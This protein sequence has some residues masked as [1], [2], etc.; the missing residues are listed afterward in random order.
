MSY[1]ETALRFASST[2]W[3]GPLEGATHSGQ[4]GVKGDGPFAL[5][6][7][8]VEGGVVREARFQTYA[9]PAARA[10]CAALCWALQ[11]RETRVALSLEPSDVQ[12]LIHGLPEGKGHLFELAVSALRSALMRPGG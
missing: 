11:G 2:Q 3:D 5:I 12:A 4:T 9:C 7:L 6:E 8:K 10:S 1:N